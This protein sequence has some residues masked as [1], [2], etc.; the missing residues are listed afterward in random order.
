MDVEE[1]DEPVTVGAVFK[2]RQVT[3]RWFVRGQIRHEIKAVNMVWRDRAGE[4]PLRHF[5]V[6][7]GGNVYQLRLNQTTM[8]WRLERVTTE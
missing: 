7:S 3:P 8:E 4:A 1:L 5:S 6:T 2:G